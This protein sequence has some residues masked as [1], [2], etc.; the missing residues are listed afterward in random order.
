MDGNRGARPRVGKVMKASVLRLAGIALLLVGCD[1]ATK[2]AA[3][4]ALSGGPPRPVIG[5]VLDLR[6]TENRDVAFELL[7]WIPDRPRATLL[8]VAGAAALAALGVVLFRRRGL[9][10]G[11]AAFLLLFAGAA[12]NYGDRLLR[13]YVVDFIHVPHWPVFNVADAYVTAGLALLALLSLRSP[14]S[15]VTG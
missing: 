9:D 11:T 2:Q 8:L 7:R 3:Q 13:G 4:H 5:S 15:V 10:A 14:R 12:G 6:Y 1:H